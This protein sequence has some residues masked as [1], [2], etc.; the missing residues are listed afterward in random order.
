MEQQGHLKRRYARL[1]ARVERLSFQRLSL[2]KQVRLQR[3]LQRCGQVLLGVGVLSGINL[4]ELQGQFIEVTTTASPFINIATVNGNEPFGLNRIASSPV[5]T[6]V[7]IDNDGDLDAFIGESGGNINYFENISTDSSV[8]MFSLMSTDGAF[9][10]AGSNLNS[11][12]VLDPS[13]TF[14]DIDKDGDIDAFLGEFFG[15]IFYF[16]NTSTDSTLPAFSA[17]SNSEPF[18]LNDVGE[19]S[20]PAFVDIDNDGDF[21]AL[22]GER[23]GNILYFENISTDSS[24][25][26][27]NLF[28]SSEPFG[29]SDIGG[30]SSPA[31][32]DFDRD[33]DIDALVGG[34][35]GNISYFENISTDVTLPV[36]SLSNSSEPFGLFDVAVGGVSPALVDIDKDG[37]VD[38]F[39]GDSSNKCIR[40]FENTS[41]DSTL[42][43]FIPPKV[44]VGYRSTPTFIDVD[45]DGDLDAF[46][47]ESRGN[48]NY[49]ENIGD[50]QN[51]VF[52]RSGSLEPFGITDI[53]LFSNYSDPTFIDIDKDGD[54]DLFIGERDG[55]VI[56][57]ENTSTNST[58]PAF[59]RSISSEPFGLSDIGSLS[60]PA[61]VDI[62]GDGDSDAFVG[63][64]DG[65]INYFENISTDST[66]PAFSLNTSSEPFGLINIGSF[67]AKPI[68]VDIDKDGDFDA[69]VGEGEGTINYFENLGNTENANFNLISTDEPF[70]LNDIGESSAP[71]II[72]IDGDGFFEAIIGNRDGCLIYFE[73]NIELP[74]E[75]LYFQAKA[76]K[77]NQAQLIWATTSEQNNS[78]FFIERSRN[79]KQFEVIGKVQG[80]GTTLEQQDYTFIDETPFEGVNYYRLQQV[81]LD[82][83]FEYTNIEAVHIN[84]KQETLAIF[85]IPTREVLNY[86]ITQLEGIKAIH[87][88][89][90]MG[91]LVK[92]DRELDGTIDMSDLPSGQ[93]TLL[94]EG[95]GRR[96]HR[97]VQKL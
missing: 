53:G 88:F 37:D 36:F 48:T 33:G 18:G 5:P 45:N 97:L 92:T 80:A 64:S 29:L 55:N 77:Q 50:A 2:E 47:G 89:D 76:T 56:F 79:G 17:S 86:N 32:M 20:K 94:F 72:D 67:G 70:G 22:V 9:G 27:F 3:R 46:I 66:L 75:L 91:R 49:L 4:T 25:P 83:A 40:Y 93:Y 51:P 57:F 19:F 24:I 23:Y 7:D 96:V 59:N 1:K 12:L 13:P 84:G 60:S 39:I 31:F 82:G 34:N 68:F 95:E 16:E 62:D 87:L 85:P 65:N 8:P 35:D 10:L 78:H 71:A 30:V 14:V 81:D 41:T 38:V 58:I 28:S 6:F 69:L 11:G 26:A 73:N 74:V 44:D 42:P 61:F 90:L 21:D 15:R 43:A 63:G 54:V 52:R